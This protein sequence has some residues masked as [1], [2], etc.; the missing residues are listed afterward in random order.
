MFYTIRKYYEVGIDHIANTGYWFR[1]RK[2]GLP[3][4]HCVHQIHDLDQVLKQCKSWFPHPYKKTYLLGL[5]RGFYVCASEG[6][7]RE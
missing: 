2:L 1:V 7:S 4:G 3:F 5:L 6:P